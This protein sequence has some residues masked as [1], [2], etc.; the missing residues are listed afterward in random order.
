MPHTLR[1][2]KLTERRNN[3]NDPR[4]LSRVPG[5]A[6]YGLENVRGRLR[7]LYGEAARLDVRANEGWGVVAS[8]EVPQ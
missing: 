7:A 4:T 8:I 5:G 6:G 1:H 3:G 2:A